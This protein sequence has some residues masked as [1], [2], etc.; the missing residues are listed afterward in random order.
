[1]VAKLATAT[2][3]RSLTAPPPSSPAQV[4]RLGH[5]AAGGDGSRSWSAWQACC[6]VRANHRC[7]FCL[8]SALLGLRQSWL[9]ALPCMQA[10]AVVHASNQHGQACMACHVAHAGPP[11]CFHCTATP[12]SIGPGWMS[13]C[14]RQS[15][16][17]PVPAAAAAGPGTHRQQPRHQDGLCRALLAGLCAFWA[18]AC[19]GARSRPLSACAHHPAKPAQCPHPGRAPHARLPGSSPAHLLCSWPHAARH[20]EHHHGR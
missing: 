2:R 15:H 10:Q 5:L 3:R 19:L 12:L 6:S 8:D 11:R 13:C 16:R 20:S 1:M 9:P 4:S 17:C 14:R 7:M 18:P